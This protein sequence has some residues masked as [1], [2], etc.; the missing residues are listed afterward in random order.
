[1]G[2]I[3]A[4]RATRIILKREKNET[5][6]IPRGNYRRDVRDRDILDARRLGENLTHQHLADLLAFL[7]SV[8]EKTAAE[9]TRWLD[10]G[11][12]PGLVEP[13][14]ESRRTEYR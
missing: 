1:M 5:E 2:M 7:R 4:Q 14:K 8:Q 10:D 11:T 12:E 3:A 13:K 6:T 9:P